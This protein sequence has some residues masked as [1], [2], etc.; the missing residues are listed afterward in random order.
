MLEERERKETRAG[1]RYPSPVGRLMRWVIPLL[2]LL[3]ILIPTGV[4]VGLGNTLEQ[5]RAELD[6]LSQS[7]VRQNEPGVSVEDEEPGPVPEPEPEGPGPEIPAYQELFPELYA[8]PHEWNSVE[9]DMVCYL[10]FDDGPSARTPEILE[11]LNRYGAKATFFVVGKESE[12][13]KQW[14]R[15]IVEEG[16]A[17]GVHSYTHEYRTIY[18]SVEAYLEDFAKEYHLIEE[19]T[20]V[21]PQVFRFP[22]GSINAY[23]GQIYQEIVSEMVRRG[24]V[25]FDWN[26]ENGDAVKN[27]PSAETMA[28]NALSKLGSASRVII[29]MHDSQSRDKTVACLPA[30]IEGYQNAGYSLEALTPEVRPIIYSYPKP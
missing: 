28:Q 24:F 8:Q 7:Q 30:V 3:A 2:A 5:T 18:D 25:Y 11:I 15:N 17:I 20:G 4:A 26:R 13:A 9:K 19:T 10:T 6:Q 22:G 14:M 12:E 16:H 1:K 21:A 29:L 27:P 23:N